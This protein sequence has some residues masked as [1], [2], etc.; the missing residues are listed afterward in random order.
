M[1]SARQRRDG[2]VVHGLDLLPFGPPAVRDDSLVDGISRAFGTG[3]ANVSGVVIFGLS[4]RRLRCVCNVSG[5]N[6]EEGE[7]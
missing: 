7:V 2:W 4:P 6:D 3:S 1:R 5:D